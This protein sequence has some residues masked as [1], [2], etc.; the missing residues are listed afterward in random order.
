MPIQPGILHC[1]KTIGEGISND[2]ITIT[3][4]IYLEENETYISFNR[5]ALYVLPVDLQVCQGL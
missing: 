5:L 1:R 4:N 2:T 3:R